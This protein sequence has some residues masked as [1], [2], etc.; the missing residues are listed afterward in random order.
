MNSRLALRELAVAR[1]AEASETVELGVV[2]TS[3]CCGTSR[4]VDVF[5]TSERHL[6]LLQEP[7]G[8]SVPIP[9]RKLALLESVLLGK[10]PKVVAM[11][12]QRSLSSITG[13]TQDCLRAMGLMG[14][15]AQASVFLTMAARAWHRPESSPRIATASTLWV[16]DERFEVVS[17][18]RPDL[19]LPATLSLAEA[20]V[21][22]S[23]LAGESYAQIS[24]ARE[25]SQRT[26][27][28]Q[29]AAAFRKLGVS[30]RRA[31]IER[32]IQR[33]ASLA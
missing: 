20:T 7:A 33:S 15:A 22:R 3:L 31:T 23:L 2:W 14:G 4:F 5:A 18:S 30:G 26:V 6:A 21:L 28:N 11:E 27:A 13:A 32:L 25:T 16:E 9:S 1:D 29:L 24:S 19:R 12:R 10:A 17:V 8:V